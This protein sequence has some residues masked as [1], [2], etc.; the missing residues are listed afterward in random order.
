MKIAVYGVSRSGKDYLLERVVAHLTAQ[1]ISA[2][3]IKGSATLNELSNQEYGIPLKQADEEK[4]TVLRNHFIDIVE[5]T[6]LTHDVVFVDGHY[7]FIDETGFNTVFTKADKY[8]YDHFFY[9]DTLTKKI[10]EFSRNDP[11][12]PQDLTIQTDK[13]AAWKC[14]EI[15]GLGAACDELGKELIILDENTQNCIQ[16]ITH[17]ITDFS[18]FDYPSIAKQLVNQFLET[19][20]KKHSVAV[21]LD[22]DNTLSENDTTYDFCDFLNIEKSALK[23][24]FAGDRYSSYQFFQVQN[25]YQQFNS[26]ELEEAVKYAVPKIQ[27]SNKVWTFVKQQNTKAYIC[28]LTSGVQNIWQNK[29]DEL[30]DIDNVWGNV[31]DK[32]QTFFVTPLLKKHITLAFKARGVQV[33]AIG[34]SVIDIPMLKVAEQG[35]IVAHKKLNQAVSE[36]FLRNPNSQ[37]KQIFATQ[38]H[39]PIKQLF[40]KEN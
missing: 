30:G 39:Y 8:C 13:I 35:Y 4:R 23:L 26:E 29:A 27:I 36:Y 19:N 2:V 6:S 5:K 33:I 25:L 17:W 14:F 1:G 15:K 16:F 34:D 24:I 28:A 38:W 40:Y 22:C 31:T 20:K 10:V 11:R 3:H 18:R 37:I 12:R 9:L 21:L 32:T 7:A